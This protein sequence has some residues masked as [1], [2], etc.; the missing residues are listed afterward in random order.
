MKRGIVSL[1]AVATVLTGSY[2]ASAD[3]L[4][5][6]LAAAYS[7][8]PQLMAQRAALRATDEGVSQAKAGFLPTINADGSFQRGNRISDIIGDVGSDG[9]QIPERSIDINND[10]YSLSLDQNLFRGFQDRNAV[11]QAKAGVKA[12]RAQL[13]NVEQQVLLDAVTAYMNVVR[14][15]A[16]VELNENNVQVLQRQ[17]QASQ[18]RFRVGE[19]TRTDV[20]QSEARL[21]NARSQ[22]LSAEATL[23]ASRAQYQRV[24]GSQP[25]GLETPEQ[26]PALPSSLDDAIELAMELSPGVKAAVHNEKAA[27]Y[28][29]NRAKGS[30][31]PTVD[32]RAS[33]NRSEGI[34]SLGPDIVFPAVGDSTQVTVNVRVPIYAGG[35]RHSQI[36]Q[37]KQ[38]RSQRMLE[39][40]QAERVA[41]ENVFVAWD[42]YRAAT[43]QIKSTQASVRANEIALEGVR[44]EAFVGSRTT[45]DVLNAEQE[46]L[47]SRV[48]YVRAQRD[49]FVAAYNLIA[50]TGRLTARDLGLGVSV[51]DE[52]RYYDKV[53][54]NKFI[55]FSTDAK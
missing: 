50:A 52:Q 47:N 31:L 20:A 13:Q 51:Y 39:I 23:A 17:L 54:A 4:K 24:V 1:M 6:A 8:N 7:S 55:G 28:S 44:Q 43:G 48:S 37:A 22:L 12:G 46:L 49:E 15:N 45:L 38:V 29:L 27:K 14:D 33:Y 35:Q 9:Q 19:V 30:L 11:Q 34:Q 3:T 18:D 32:V 36:R 5:E 25:T 10:S 53:G 26:K 42:Q 16:V 21:E 41:Q 40:R 2:A